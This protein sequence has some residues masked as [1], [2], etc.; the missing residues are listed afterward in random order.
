MPTVS[1]DTIAEVAPLPL[2]RQVIP[3]FS[4]S[5]A[6][7][8]SF[9]PV[10]DSCE[11]TATKV[12]QTPSLNGWGPLKATID[13]QT[14]VTGLWID[15]LE[16]ENAALR[17][18]Q[19]MASAVSNQNQHAMTASFQRLVELT[20]HNRT[21]MERVVRLQDNVVQEIVKDLDEVLLKCRTVLQ[22]RNDSLQAMNRYVEAR[23]CYLRDMC[24]ATLFTIRERE[25]ND[26]AVQQFL[27]MSEKMQAMYEMKN[28]AGFVQCM[29]SVLHGVPSLDLAQTRGALELCTDTMLGC[30]RMRAAYQDLHE[31]E[32]DVFAQ[33]LHKRTVEEGP[34][35]EDA[36]WR[37]ILKRMQVSVEL[38][39]REAI[40][41]H[42]V[43]FNP[44]IMQTIRNHQRTI[45]LESDASSTIDLVLSAYGIDPATAR[46]P[47]VPLSYSPGQGLPLPYPGED[48]YYL[49]N[50]AVAGG[51]ESNWAR[52]ARDA[53][54]L[55]RSSALASTLKTSKVFSGGGSGVAKDLGGSGT[56]EDLSDCS[57]EDAVLSGTCNCTAC[58]MKN[59]VESVLKSK[60][61]P[62]HVCTI[63][64]NVGPET[65]DDVLNSLG[66]IPPEFPDECDGQQQ[67]TKT[68]TSP[69][70]R[71]RGQQKKVRVAML[72][73]RKLAEA[74]THSNAHQHAPPNRPIYRVEA[75]STS[76][77]PSSSPEADVVTSRKFFGTDLDK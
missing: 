8:Y 50:I 1:T 5:I 10:V 22:A 24:C 55:R 34:R 66:E 39:V 49:R 47:S 21:L 14:D 19:Q 13:T 42:G 54:I 12:T 16:A 40:K 7:S 65:L 43:V 52:N 63:S 56:S 35:D 73:G 17:L 64:D 60:N 31:Y 25:Q 67:E 23:E 29:E 26:F 2:K 18:Q 3:D 77:T 20:N 30:V 28:H 59:S 4:Q 48:D 58:E 57:E 75:R 45:F 68:V 11:K 6:P 37:G 41:Q 71:P 76:T 72:R 27:T 33:T 51:I 53:A 32:R 38:S 61:I 69:V 70:A 74:G 15:G 62:F 46:G 36:D 44:H 9:P